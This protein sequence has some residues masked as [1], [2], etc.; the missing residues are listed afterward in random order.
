MCFPRSSL[1]HLYVF[2][3]YTLFLKSDELLQF[4]LTYKDQAFRTVSIYG[5]LC[6]W[7]KGA[8]KRAQ[9]FHFPSN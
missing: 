2:L 4:P 9:C 3:L 6:T 1:S 7:T 8:K 5:M